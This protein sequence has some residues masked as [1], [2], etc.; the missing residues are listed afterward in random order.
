[1]DAGA[2]EDTAP[3]VV[4]VA[5]AA[6]PPSDDDPT[7]EALDEA[8]AEEDPAAATGEEDAAADKDEAPA[9]EEIC[10]DVT[11][12][13]AAVVDEAA[14]VVE[15][16]AVGL[17][18][19]VVLLAAVD[20][21]EVGV[22]EEVLAAA[23]SVVELTP[24]DRVTSCRPLSRIDSSV[25]VA[26]PATERRRRTTTEILVVSFMAYMITNLNTTII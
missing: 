7:A 15:A 9:K 1:M 24:V 11:G 5:A 3:L 2:P 18:E 26:A 16:A 13:E 22:I 23:V 20:G 14:A 8:A 21:V 25:P 4:V 19:G 10:C 17:A 6:D 12:L